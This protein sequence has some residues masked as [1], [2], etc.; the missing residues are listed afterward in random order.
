MKSLV[1]YILEENNKK[2]ID[3]FVESPNPKDL[4]MIFTDKIDN[5]LREKIKSEKQLTKRIK[6]NFIIGLFDDTSAIKKHVKTKNIES[7]KYYL[8]GEK[9]FK[10]IE[11]DIK[12]LNSDNEDILG[13]KV[14]IDN[15]GAY[16]YV[17][18]AIDVEGN[19]FLSD[20]ELE[21]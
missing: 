12:L 8:A 18:C 15:I 16:V 17:I 2:L 11:D 5:Q 21:F 6:D 20:N 14:I 13:F 3:F 19:L 1:E 9:E 7:G 4:Y 10:L